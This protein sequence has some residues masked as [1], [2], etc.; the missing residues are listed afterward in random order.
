M[1]TSIKLDKDEQGDMVDQKLYRDM[2]ASLLYLTASRPN[3]MYSVCACVG[4]QSSPRTSHLI[5]VNVSFDM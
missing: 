2:I 1:S 4:F 3:I 5:I